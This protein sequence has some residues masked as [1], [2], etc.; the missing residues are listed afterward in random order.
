MISSSD[1]SEGLLV[2]PIHR[3]LSIDLVCFVNVNS[4]PE[5]RVDALTSQA[6]YNEHSVITV[7]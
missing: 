1:F 5:L 7:T 4:Y 3:F 2:G 6:T